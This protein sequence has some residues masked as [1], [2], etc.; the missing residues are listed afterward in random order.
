MFRWSRLGFLRM[1]VT[2]AIFNS[3][4]T[5]A[6][7]ELQFIICVMKGS[8]SGTHILSKTV[9]VGSSWQDVELDFTIRSLMAAEVVRVKAER[10]FVE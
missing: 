6:D 9:G 3:A 2:A 8:T 5:M 10:E 7:T 4:G 1:G